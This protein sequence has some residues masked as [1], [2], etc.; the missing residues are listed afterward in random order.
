MQKYLLMLL[1]V[2]SGVVM[3]ENIDC[4]NAMN[5]LEMNQC[6]NRDLE[7]AKI[8]QAKYLATSLERHADDP[9]LITAIKLAQADWQAYLSSHCRSVY[10]Q[11]RDGTIRDVR[12]LSC[13]TQLTK[14]R[15]H[16]LWENFLTYADST[17]PVLPEP[18]S[19]DLVEF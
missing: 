16:E 3:A 18:S 11:W 8:E 9:E 12:A 4:D 7:S 19:V 10:T 6:A 15:T 2:F 17:P 5:T 14:Q 1:A 13:K